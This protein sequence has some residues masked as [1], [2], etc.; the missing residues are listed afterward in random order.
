MDF[1]ICFAW[2]LTSAGIALL[3]QKNKVQ[4]LVCKT[5]D[6]ESGHLQSV[7]GPGFLAW[8]AEK[9]KQHS[10]AKSWRQDLQVTTDCS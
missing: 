3:S 10:S 7:E 2:C 1:G 8:V 5:L 4:E 6:M 9:G